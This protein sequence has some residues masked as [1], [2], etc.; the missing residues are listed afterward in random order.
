MQQPIAKPGRV[1]PFVLHRQI[2]ALAY[3]GLRSPW[4]VWHVT[5]FLPADAGEVAAAPRRL[6]R[7]RRLGRIAGTVDRDEQGGEFARARLAEGRHA[8]PQV[9]THRSG[10]SRSTF[11]EPGGPQPPPTA[12]RSG[13]LRPSSPRSRPRPTRRA[14]CRQAALAVARV[15]RR[16][17]IAHECGVQAVRARRSARPPASWPIARSG[18]SGR[19][20][21][22]RRVAQ[23]GERTCGG[24][25]R[26]R[27]KPRVVDRVASIAPTRA[28]RG[29]AWRATA[30][31]AGAAAR[32]AGCSCVVA[33]SA[34]SAGI[35]CCSTPGR[36][37]STSS[38]WPTFGLGVEHADELAGGQR[39]AAVAAAMR[40]QPLVLHHHRCRRS[41]TTN[42]RRC[43]GRERPLAR[44]R[45]L[46]RGAELQHEVV[47]RRRALGVD[48][49]DDGLVAAAPAWSGRAG[50]PTPCGSSQDVR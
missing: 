18:C 43:R 29:P 41:T 2:H 5:Q 37:H 36:R 50:P 23:F 35:G 32:G 20:V 30:S 34:T 21:R 16:A 45:H 7:E 8:Q 46:D 19:R 13:A 25:C 47:L 22:A 12:V 44:R 33:A 15:A 10:R 48:P 14:R 28:R 38:D 9:R 39:D 31:A 26:Q 40:R 49:V 24:R 27:G 3:R 4:N 11:C 42:C 17:A 1:Q 6:D